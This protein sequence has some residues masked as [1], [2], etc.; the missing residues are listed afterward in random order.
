MSA[1]LP[2]ATQ[3]WGLVWRLL[4]LAAV[5]VLSC[6]AYF[7]IGD[8][9][10]SLES[11]IRHRMAIFAFV[12]QHRYLA[13]IV[14]LAVYIVTVAF[15]VPGAA[16]L[17][18][19]GGFLFGWIGGSAVAVIGATVGSTLIFLAARTALGEPLL[20]WAG[21]RAN[22]LA[23]SF[24]EDAFSYLLFLR[25]VP[26]F[27]FFIVNLVPAFAGVRVGPFIAATALGIIPAAIVFAL[28]GTGLD[29]IIMAQKAAYDQCV[30]SG[31]PDCR[32]VFDA[33][34]VLT[35]QL[36]IALVALGTLVLML[37][38]LRRWRLRSGTSG[39]LR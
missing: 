13:L 10:L 26:I 39:N 20:K 37:V 19:V 27:P 31:G 34:D 35:P 22:Q 2:S 28:A 29:S 6:V 8:A 5:I 24:R 18:V 36:I 11:L 16:F 17:T 1:P 25:L 23:Q 30:A 14:Y 4:P 7:G 3:P 38:V 33:S 9:T 12:S 15:S 32:M 21:P